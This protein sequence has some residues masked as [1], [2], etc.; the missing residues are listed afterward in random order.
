MYDCSAVYVNPQHFQSKDMSHNRYME[1]MYSKTP[2]GVCKKELSVDPSSNMVQC[3]CTMEMGAFDGLSQSYTN[4]LLKIPSNI[5]FNYEI[6]FE[7]N[8]PTGPTGPVGPT[9]NIELTTKK[10]RHIECIHQPPTRN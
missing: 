1:T 9:G 10:N 5:N 8:G 6:E 4:S 3:E 2:C 7:Y